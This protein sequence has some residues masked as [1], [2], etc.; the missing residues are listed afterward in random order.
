M[1][2]DK[3]DSKIKKQLEGREINPS[4]RAWNQLSAELDAQ[5]QKPTKKY[6]W[7][8]IA[9]SFLAGI[10]ISSFLFNQQGIVSE[11]QV[12]EGN[13]V[14]EIQQESEELL[15][16][17]KNSVLSE[18]EKLPQQ[19]N[20]QVVAVVSDVEETENEVEIEIQEKQTRKFEKPKTKRKTFQQERIAEN[21]GVEPKTEEIGN[22]EGFGSLAGSS[23]LAQT[24][25]PSTEEEVEKL[26]E[27]ARQKAQI[28]NFS[29]PYNLVNAQ[30]LL[31]N[32]EV[33]D[34]ESFKEK[35]FYAL[36]NGLKHVKSTVIK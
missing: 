18:T 25:T 32:I 29:N 16:Q 22:L 34:K 13:T 30:D 27:A 4:P 17:G 1:A 3:F 8:G 36:E 2:A 20:T 14:E 6:W 12:V 9:A 7:I 23:Q 11:N 15:P 24:E 10:L 28:R 33:E 31:E 35:V 21:K 5:E 19:K 26:L